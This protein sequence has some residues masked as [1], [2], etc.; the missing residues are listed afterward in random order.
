MGLDGFFLLDGGF[1][2]GFFVDG[3]LDRYFLLRGGGLAVTFFRVYFSSGGIFFDSFEFYEVFNYG[4]LFRGL[5]VRF[6]RGG[7]FGL[8]FGDGCFILFGYRE[9]FFVGFEFVLLVGRF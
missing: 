6:S 1:L 7:F 8:G 3:F 4:S 5:G 2:L 9:I